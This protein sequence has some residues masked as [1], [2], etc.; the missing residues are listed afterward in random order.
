[1]LEKYDTVT[2]RFQSLEEIQYTVAEEKMP[3]KLPS[4]RSDEK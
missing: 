4:R 3:L 1:M 2:N